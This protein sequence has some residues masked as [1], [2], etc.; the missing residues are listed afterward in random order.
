MY[1]YFGC[2]IIGSFFIYIVILYKGFSL[3]YTIS[4]IIAVLGV[5]NGSLF[6][7]LALLFQNLI[8]IP[9]IFLLSISGIDLYD[10]LKSHCIN[11]KIEVIKHTLIMFITLLLSVISSIIEVYVST[12]LLI[13]LK[14]FL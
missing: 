14:E 6:A 2:T 11:L 8:F 1:G 5:K 9:A 13:F 3:G 12:N 4:S 10:K 7:L